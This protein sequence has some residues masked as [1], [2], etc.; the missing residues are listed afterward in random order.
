MKGPPLMCPSCLDDALEGFSAVLWKIDV[1]GYEEKVL[2]GAQVQL[3]RPSLKALLLETES[4]R[5]LELLLGNGFE[6]VGYDPFARA[7]VKRQG[8]TEQN[9]LWI[10]DR[11]FCEERVRTAP[12][13]TVSGISF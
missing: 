10:R 11:P 9:S 12:L 8:K 7:F 5:I 6:R 13:I 4:P 3:A 1:E 2:E